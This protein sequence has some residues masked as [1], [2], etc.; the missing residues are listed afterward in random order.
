MKE[1]FMSIKQYWTG[2]VMLVGSFAVCWVAAIAIED[3]GL[4][5]FRAYQMTS[6]KPRPQPPP[7]I[8]DQFMDPQWQRR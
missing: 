4:H 7:P 6:A 8:W 5:P 3:A 2:V 1:P